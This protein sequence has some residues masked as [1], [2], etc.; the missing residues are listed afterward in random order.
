MAEIKKMKM[1]WSHRL[2]ELI[3]ENSEIPTDVSFKIGEGRKK[4]E[5]IVEAHKLVMSMVSEPFRKMLYVTNTSDKEAKEI[6]VKD[7]TVAAFRA[8]VNAI[9]N[10]KTIYESLKDKTV[11][12]IFDV[13]NL[14]KKYQIP[15]LVMS[16]RDCLVSLPLS[17]ETVMEVAIV[18]VKY[19][20]TFDEEAKELL[21][22][23]AK[24]IKTKFT[25]VNS[26]LEFHVVNKEHADIVGELF[27]LMYSLEPVL[28]HNCRQT[29]CKDGQGVTEEEV[30]LDLKVACRQSPFWV[31]DFIGSLG[32]VARIVEDE[33]AL[34]DCQAGE[35]QDHLTPGDEYPVIFADSYYYFGFNCV[36]IYNFSFYCVNA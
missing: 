32:T 22:H 20:D 14:A 5:N 10:N 12:K 6:T 30:R 27:T 16:T 26:V 2:A 33:V 8:I 9:Y 17:E 31:D 18:A 21:L 35:G 15:E 25:D 7:T 19:N 3:Q 23:C 11:D 28:C 36:D 24:F 1:D 13:L 34:E 29:P 4:M